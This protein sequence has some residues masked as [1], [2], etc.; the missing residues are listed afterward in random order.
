MAISIPRMRNVAANSL[1]DAAHFR[2]PPAV[3]A[4]IDSGIEPVQAFRLAKGISV[5]ELAD[6][7]GIAADRIAS[8]E[9]GKGGL[10][11]TDFKVIGKA[12]AVPP[13]LLPND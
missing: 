13:E 3:L 9:A 7:T 4:A 11:W 12:L 1:T 8:F 6:A 2:I 5:Q 10:H